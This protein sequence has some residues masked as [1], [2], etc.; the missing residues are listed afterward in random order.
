[1]GELSGHFWIR[2]WYC[3]SAP[4]HRPSSCFEV[5]S[6]TIIF[7]RV[8]DTIASE[9]DLPTGNGELLETANVV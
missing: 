7:L 8:A 2:N 3:G 4:L 9:T 6:N 1:M 5:K